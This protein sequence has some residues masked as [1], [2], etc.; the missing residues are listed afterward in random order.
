MSHFLISCGGTGGH[1]SPGI[2]LAE[3]LAERGHAATLLISE[4]KVDARL[5]EKYPHLSFARMPGSETSL[6]V[7]GLRSNRHSASTVTVN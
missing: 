4:K 5:I 3:G 6:L 7:V 1:L 2:A